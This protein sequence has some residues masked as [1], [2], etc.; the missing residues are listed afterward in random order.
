MLQT[1]LSKRNWVYV[2]GANGIAKSKDAGDTWERLDTLSRPDT[3]PVRA[4][5]ASPFDSN[6]IVY[7]AAQSAYR[8]IDEGRNWATFQFDS[9]QVASVARYHP[10]ASGVIYLGFRKNP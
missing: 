4:F 1:N 5:D 6:E 8:S 2:A 9:S 3:F 7:G 10:R